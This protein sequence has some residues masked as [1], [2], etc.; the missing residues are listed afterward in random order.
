MVSVQQGAA[1][2]TSLAADRP[3]VA[4]EEE[5]VGASSVPV[6]DVQPT[7]KAPD[8]IGASSA[9]RNEPVNDVEGYVFTDVSQAS[10]ATATLRPGEEV[11]YEADFGGMPTVR[12]MRANDRGEDVF[13]GWQ[14]R[15]FQAFYGAPV[16]SHAEA[17]G[18]YEEEGGRIFGLGMPGGET[19]Y[20]QSGDE[21]PYAA[22]SEGF[23]AIVTSQLAMGP[24]ALRDQK[25]LDAANNYLAR[26][27][28]FSFTRPL[29]MDEWRGYV[30]HALAQAVAY[31]PIFDDGG[32]R[33]V[34]AIVADAASLVGIDAAQ[35]QAWEEALGLDSVFSRLIGDFGPQIVGTDEFRQMLVD[36]MDDMI[37]AIA[38]VRFGGQTQTIADYA[39]RA[40]GQWALAAGLMLEGEAKL[41]AVHD[42]VR[43]LMKARK[44]HVAGYILAMAF[45]H[46]ALNEL[47]NDG[48][49]FLPRLSEAEWRA[50]ARILMVG[51]TWSMAS[52]RA[53]RM[54]LSLREN[55]TMNAVIAEANYQNSIAELHAI[56]VTTASDEE[57]WAAVDRTGVPED[58]LDFAISKMAASFRQ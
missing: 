4:P 8:H 58:I 46:S 9:S 2:T 38:G 50:L 7:A 57:F 5:S 32:A 37:G 28:P 1:F 36:S 52:H 30:S 40:E 53:F 24:D 3:D 35:F 55:E 20:K 14:E 41:S 29:T 6:A 16:E 10:A 19:A 13:V 23:F 48:D 54:H 51:D 25:F 27:L 39:Y 34:G 56:D 15:D 22:I 12:F 11:S 33:T 17:E 45:K 44:K 47:P 18:R 31:S 43:D 49:E 26:E 42:L 21:E